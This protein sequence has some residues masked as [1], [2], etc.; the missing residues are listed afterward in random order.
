MFEQLQRRITDLQ[1]H[2]D[3]AS[4]LLQ[5]AVR[6]TARL[7]QRSHIAS[8]IPTIQHILGGDAVS[9]EPFYDAWLLMYAAIRRLDEL[10]DDDVVDEPLPFAN[11]RGAQYNF[12]FGV[13]LLAA[14]LLDELVSL[15]TPDRLLR[16]RRLW[17]DSMLQM[18]AGQQ[19]DLIFPVT[20]IS[21]MSLDEY[22][23]IAVAKTG[24]TFA[25]AFGGTATLLTDD[26]D[27]VETLAAVGEVYGTLLQYQDDILDEDEQHNT[28]ITLPRVLA[29]LPLSEQYSTNVSAAFWTHLYPLYQIAVSNA[30]ASCA[31]DVRN[32][33]LA[34]FTHAFETHKQEASIHD[35]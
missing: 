29:R 28:T 17:T 7:A 22:Q 34:L 4:V 13:Y 32:G 9:I 26:M 27:L 10:Q 31:S 16:L 25:L 5:L 12:V 18:A 2:Q 1:M 15:I 14:S 30:L 21:R 3:V 11:Q 23:Q 35:T 19:C 20:D 8:V 6:D 24:A 33:V